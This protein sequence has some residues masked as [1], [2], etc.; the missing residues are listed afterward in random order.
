MIAKI[1]STYPS[2]S[3]CAKAWGVSPQFLSQ[4]ITGKRPI[5]PRT[6]LRINALHGTQLELLCPSTWPASAKQA[7][8]TD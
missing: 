1:V 7:Q 4:L 6:A 8:P 2:K 5:P 3:A